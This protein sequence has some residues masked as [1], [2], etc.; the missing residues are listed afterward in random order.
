MKDLEDAFKIIIAYL[1][2]ELPVQGGGTIS[3][4][5]YHINEMNLEKEDT[6]LDSIPNEDCRFV[7]HQRQK[8]MK[9]FKSWIDIS[10]AENVAIT[11]NFDAVAKDFIISV[12]SVIYDDLS[13]NTFYKSVRMAEV[14][15]N[16]MVG[17]FR[18][19]KDYGFAF[20]EMEANTLPD[21][22]EVSGTKAL[23]SGVVYMVTIQ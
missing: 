19:V 8:D 17:F 15:K 16:I 21:R 13:K 11:P 9:L 23:M 6:L 7:L 3:R 14:L 4:L 12:S 22:V 20:G 5:N 1:M 18:D 10:V 2:E